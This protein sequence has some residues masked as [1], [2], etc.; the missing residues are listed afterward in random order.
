MIFNRKRLTSDIRQYLPALL[1][2]LGL[3]LLCRFLRLQ[4]CP[5][6]LL[7]GIP[8]PGC[9]MTRALFALLT[10]NFREAAKWNILIYS[11]LPHGILFLL[12]RYFSVNDHRIF[13]ERL[14]IP[15]GL[16]LIIYY[17]YRM[18]TLYPHTEPML[19]YTH[20]LSGWFFL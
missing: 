15:Q 7:L 3:I 6:K 12:F 9:G 1:L 18:L 11:L 8:C 2:A 10:L 17:I 13:F 4:T 20:S 5:A 14:L 16:L 19:P